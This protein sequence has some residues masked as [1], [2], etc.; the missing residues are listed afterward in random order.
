MRRLSLVGLGFVL[1]VAACAG[2]S[3]GAAA[4]EPVET[5]ATTS[6]TG[7]GSEPTATLPPTTVPDFIPQTE[8]VPFLE[9]DL[10]GRIDA[11][12]ERANSIFAGYI[13]TEMG[14]SGDIRWAPWLLDLMRLGGSTDTD[15]R[16][17]R[18]LQALSGIPATGD[19]QDDA[20]QY[21]IWARTEEIDPGPGYIEFKTSLFGIAH[22]DFERLLEGVNDRNVLARIRWGGVA[23]AG[24][25]ELNDQARITVEEADFMTDEELVLGVVV[26]GQAV[27][28]PLR[29][30]ARHELAN[31]HIEGIPVAMVYCTLCKSGILFDRR[32]DGQVLDFQTSGMLIDSNK[33]MVDIQTET[34]WHHLSGTGIGGPHKGHVLDRYAVEV[35][36]WDEWVAEHPETETLSTPSPKYFPDQPDRPPIAFEYTPGDAYAFY[37]S[38]DNVWFP[39]LEHPDV[40][41]RKEEVVTVDRDGLAVAFGLSDVEVAEPFVYVLGDE[42]L[43]VVGHSGGARV[44]SGRGLDLEHLQPLDVAPDGATTETLRLTDGRE[45]PRIVS[46]Q[47]F[48]FAWFGLHQ[49]TVWWPDAE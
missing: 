27:A 1:L 48:W 37:Y 38:S 33:I 18:A 30:L 36:R 32:V 28:Y 45:L 23:R 10:L 35:A 14:Q 40:F 25:P 5:T 4:P 19:P 11:F 20:L 13:A 47:S 34:L 46:S 3:D 2:D 22:P 17:A 15:V 6:T 39:V 49:D 24:I 43:A 7:A 42:P 41:E 21:G 29:F 26:E 44:Y 9:R 31:D 16:T 12:N 8:G